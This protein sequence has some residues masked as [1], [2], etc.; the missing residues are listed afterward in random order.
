MK[1]YARRKARRLAVQAL[2][3]WQHQANDIDEI[4]TQFL[5]K[6]NPKKVDQEY[7][8]ELWLP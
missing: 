3:Q 7:F 1:Q 4:K 2:Y 5:A 6:I 8:L